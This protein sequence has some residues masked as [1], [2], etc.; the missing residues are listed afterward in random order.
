[1]QSQTKDSR[2]ESVW[3]R[4]AG[5]ICL[6]LILFFFCLGSHRAL[7][8]HEALLAG[9]AKQ[10]V[11]SGDWLVPRIG[12][13]TWLEK[14]PL[15]QWLA[16]STAV[17]ATDFNEWTM[18]LPFAFAG[19]IVVLLTVRLMTLLFDSRIGW[20]SGVIQASSVYMVMYARLAES[21]MVLL[22]FVMAAMTLFFEVE[23]Q[24]EVL[25]QTQLSRRRLA[26]WILVGC[27][28]LAKGPLFGSVLICFTCGGWLFLKRDWNAIRRWFSPLGIILA[29]GI[30]VAWP[31]AVVFSDPTA[32]EL[33][34][35]HLFGRAAGT[36][37]Y[38]QPFWYYLVQWPT[39]LMPWTPFLFVAAAGSWKSAYR[40]AGS[41][42]FCWWWFLGQMAILSC[43]SGKHHHYLIYALPAMSPIIAQG[44][45]LTADGIRNPLRS[46]KP[47]M[48]WLCGGAALLIIGGVILG[49]KRPGLRLEGY[50][51]LPL[52][53]LVLVAFAFLLQNR[54]VRPIWGTLLTV[55]VLG[56]IY[57]QVIVMPR[58]D[59]SAADKQFLAEVDQEVGP[60]A[61]LSAC[62]SQEMALHIFYLQHPVKGIW[63]PENLPAALPGVQDFYVVARG[64]AQKELES[65]GKVEQVLQSGFTRR[66]RSAADRFTLFHVSRTDFTSQPVVAEKVT[67]VSLR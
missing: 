19:L 43:S 7:T 39:Q 25:T 16:A 66:E 48:I 18:R 28:N 6:C 55:I 22:A 37:G 12:D 65:L 34:K 42:R 36:L 21:D 54:A 35:R 31:I 30:A 2:S 49:V 51:L 38:T 60:D 50:V 45:I 23:T 14:P 29:A 53:S 4:P 33:W 61:I 3:Y 10:M 11:L 62:G 20:L 56:H 27:T 40:T 26:F 13:Q 41:D 5:L 57:A 59:T 15:P 47:S 17:I 64:Q 32:L 46:L 8:A 52:L 9:T 58:V 24:H 67:A 44:L 1:M 63:K